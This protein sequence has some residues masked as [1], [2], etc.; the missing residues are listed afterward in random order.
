MR[1]GLW[2]IEGS[3]E[4]AAIEPG[5]SEKAAKQQALEALTLVWDACADGVTDF[6]KKVDREVANEVQRGTV[7][8]KVRGLPLS[9][10]DEFPA[11]VDSP[12]A[13]RSDEDLFRE[14]IHDGTSG[15]DSIGDDEL[16]NIARAICADWTA[17]QTWEQIYAPVVDS[18]IEPGDAAVLLAA[19]GEAFC[20]SL[21]EH[22]SERVFG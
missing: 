19:A 12:E 7:L 22:M 20:P 11:E 16:L 13:T 17:G 14:R 2:S 18:G 8:G 9:T 6:P 10:E 5:L 3:T 15:L 1:N 4:T 21:F